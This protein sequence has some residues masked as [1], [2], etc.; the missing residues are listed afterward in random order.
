MHD[1]PTLF[2]G[3]CVGCDDFTR[4]DGSG[5]CAECLEK[6]DRDMLRQRDWDCSAS[7]YCVPPDKRE[8]LRRAVIGRYGSD[9]ELIAP[10]PRETMET[11]R[12]KR[13]KRRRTNKSRRA[14][15]A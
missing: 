6:L 8:E 11:S 4:V 1:G 14:T 12:R 7:A 3:E 9:L 2:Q 5:L 15:G 13:R 10:G